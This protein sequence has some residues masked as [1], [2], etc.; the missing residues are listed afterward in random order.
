MRT[1]LAAAVGLAL[2]GVLVVGWAAFGPRAGQTEDVKVVEVPTPPA[3]VTLVHRLQRGETLGDVFEDHGLSPAATHAIAEAMGEFESPRR[4]RPGVAIHFVSRPGE[5]PARIRV[6][7]D[8][9]RI[10]HL[11]SGDGAAPSWSARLD[12]VQ[13]VR[14]TLLLAGLIQS[15][16]F[17]A[18]M[19]G[20]LEALGDGGRFDVAYRISQVFAWQID[21]WRDL[22]RNDAYRLLIEREVRPDGS[23]RD[24]TVLAADFRNDRR[25][26]T[27]VRFEHAAAERA[28]YYD[29]AGEALRGQFLLAPLDIVRV[30]SG[31]NLRRFHPVLRRTR[32]HLGVDY[33]A[34][35]GTPVRATGAGRVT[36]A[37][38]W[39]NYGNAVEIRHA[40]NIRTR[41]AHLANVA[42][43]VA[44]GTQ[45]EQG[46][47]IGYVGD[48]GLATA[49]HLHYEF[50]RNGAQVNPARLQLPRAEP[51]PAE[52][53]ERFDTVQHAVLARLRSLPM[54]I[55][56][57]QRARRT[58]D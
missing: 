57:T 31:Y 45:V 39:G 37:G 27:G 55:H 50:L 40:N 5:S 13:V 41:Y 18:E 2:A 14:D 28:E 44:T 19:S 24:A 51:I 7:L 47:V 36:R 34:A 30:T 23:V 46:Q 43:G 10:L 25:V 11:W 17:D 9:D 32:P 21:F 8:P 48:T 56:P 15:N 16:L 1:R 22:R 3:P 54:P 26:L 4:L 49:P 12:S 42:R 29:E 58:Q 38:W 20:D 53:R 6:H 33:G 52:L 35:R